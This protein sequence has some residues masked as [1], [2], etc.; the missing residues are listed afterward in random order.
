MAGTGPE[1]LHALAVE[2]LDAC[3]ESLDTIPTFNPGLA[4][5][6]ERRFVSPGLPVWDCCEM[7]TVHVDG[8]SESAT[9]PAGLAQGRRQVY[10]RINLV[11]LVVTMSRCIPVIGGTQL[12]AIPEPDDLQSAAEQLNADGWALWNHLFNMIR[13]EELFEKCLE[14]FWDGMRAV[15]PS[16]GCA[17]WTTVFR[18]QL[19]G[20]ED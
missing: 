6:P 18:V 5:A 17:G 4:G 12:D 11:S 2:L 7:L 20:Y 14:I 16:G 9:S 15:V 10:S 8:L 13:N 1:D 3:V 19:D